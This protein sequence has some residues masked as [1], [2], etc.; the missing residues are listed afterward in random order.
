MLI[1]EKIIAHL[2]RVNESSI[3]E[4]TRTT[5]E[6]D[7]NRLSGFLRACE[8]LGIVESTGKASHRKYRLKADYLKKL[9][10][11]K[12]Q[13][14]QINETQEKRQYWEFPHKTRLKKRRIEWSNDIPGG[15]ES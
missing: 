4:M 14:T 13:V 11:F 2:E 9:E 5:N 10:G 3:S 12:L 7:R 6:L 8:E 1:L 15:G